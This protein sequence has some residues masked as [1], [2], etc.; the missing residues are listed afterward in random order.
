MIFPSWRNEEKLKT[1]A[2][3]NR[4]LVVSNRAFEQHLG[5]SQI[6]MDTTGVLC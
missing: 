1:F 4:P 2:E 3:R 5:I 6:S